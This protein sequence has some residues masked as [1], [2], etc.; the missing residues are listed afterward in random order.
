M[1]KAY[2]YHTIWRAD[3]PFGI[4]SFEGEMRPKMTQKK[5]VQKQTEPSNDTLLLLLPIMSIKCWLLNSKMM[6]NEF[7][8]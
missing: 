6:V 5:Q 8:K 4:A 1:G 2:N 3:L 7:Y